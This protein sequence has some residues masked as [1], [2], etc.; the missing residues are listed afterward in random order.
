MGVFSKT[1]V[2]NTGPL[3][4]LARARLEWLPFRLFPKV[5]VPAAVARELT[6][7]EAPD[8]ER[9]RLALETGS[10]VEDPAPID[11]LLVAELDVGEA[12][13]IAVASLGGHVVILD[14]RKARK[15]ATRVYGLPVK[16]TAGLLVQAKRL[17]LI[18][19]VA[20]PIRNMLAGGYHLSNDL[21]AATLREAGEV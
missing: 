2:C 3:L 12:A 8:A 14:E 10:V 21:V 7:R 9:V 4:G 5:L 16:G 15:V 1:A 20:A 18:P 6:C 19:E 11:P 13:V 17:G